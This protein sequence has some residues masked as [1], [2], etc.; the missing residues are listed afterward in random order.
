VKSAAGIVLAIAVVAITAA[1]SQSVWST[2][3]AAEIAAIY[4]DIDAFYIDLH[5]N[6]ELAFHETETA[7][8]LSARLQAMG[9]AVTNGVAGT[10]VVGILQNGPGPTVMLRTE[11]D[12][13]PVEEKTG[14]AFASQARG[15]NAAGELVPVMHACGHDIHM[16]AWIGTARLMSEH[17]K[18]WRGTLMLVGQPAEEVGS[19]AK[20][21]I[22]DG[23][24]T[25]F[26]KPDF[27]LSVHDDDT[28]PAGQI[29]FHAGYFRANADT[30]SMTIF[31]RGGHA[32]APHN[33]IDP[34]VIAANI[35]LRLQT[36][37]SR[38]NN[39]I[40]PAVITVGSIHGGTQGNVIPSEVKLELSVRT[41]TAQVRARVLASIER[42]AKAEA[43]AANAPKPPLIETLQFNPA[44]Y[45][46]P[47]LTLRLSAALR[48]NL[49]EENVVEMPAKM[50]SEDFAHYSLA[51]VPSALLHVGAID[52]VKL[53]TARETN[54][55]VPAPHSATW[56]PEREPTLK[57]AIRA[58]VT[59]LLELF[60]SGA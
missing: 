29:G 34:V 25:R 59:E 5:R 18:D 11:I 38:E 33:T 31:G 30:L 26:R 51:G 52:P 17:R 24:F 60:R 21:M 13:L 15:K 41:Y 37:V 48:K 10:G 3:S 16:A 55:P 47:E 44:V 54:V 19:G 57:G 12:A 50:T 36:I 43:M 49:G 9:Y 40:D 45:N 28:L 20:A 6:P 58:E 27:A 1:Q 56:A 32:A 2:P 23:L 7:K 39:P 42:V 14:L 22:E 53:K 46:N 35:I 8:K 4:P